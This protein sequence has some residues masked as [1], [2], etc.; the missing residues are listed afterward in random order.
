MGV[1]AEERE[2]TDLANLE[3]RALGY[4]TPAAD[5]TDTQPRSDKDSLRLIPH[6]TQNQ[7]PVSG[8]SSELRKTPVL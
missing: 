1:L 3:G 8:L 4:S 6:P 2:C 7:R 5:P